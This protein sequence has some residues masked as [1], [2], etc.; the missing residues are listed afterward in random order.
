MPARQSTSKV[1]GG[2]QGKDAFLIVKIQ[3]VGDSQDLA[4]RIRAAETEEERSAIGLSMVKEMVV[5]CNWLDAENKR[6]L[7][8]EEWVTKLTTEEFRFISEAIRGAGS[9]DK[10]RF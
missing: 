2:P 5:D 6:I 10:K 3:T 7:E 1:M 4:D 9:S 8:D